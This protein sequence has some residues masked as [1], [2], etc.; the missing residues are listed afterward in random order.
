MTF[1]RLTQSRLLDSYRLMSRMRQ[2]ENV[3]EITSQGNVAAWGLTAFAKP[4]L[5]TGPLHLSI[6]EESIATGDAYDLK[7]SR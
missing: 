2:F 4:A 7:I 3:A 6:R 1:E 5:L